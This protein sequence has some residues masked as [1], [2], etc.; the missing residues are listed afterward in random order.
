MKSTA[1]NIEGGA[2]ITRQEI[3]LCVCKAM[4]IVLFLIMLLI[5]RIYFYYAS[6]G[7]YKV[8]PYISVTLCLT[9]LAGFSIDFLLTPKLF[10]KFSILQKVIVRLLLIFLPIA[11]YL[12]ALY[13]YRVAWA[14]SGITGV[15][16]WD[17]CLTLDPEYDMSFGVLRIITILQFISAGLKILIFREH[18]VGGKFVCERLMGKK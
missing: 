18:K 9:L 7:S 5:T 17:K 13:L 3:L 11:F 4:D 10:S 16:H 12:E 1:E 6:L 2:Y 15:L 14:E 8:S